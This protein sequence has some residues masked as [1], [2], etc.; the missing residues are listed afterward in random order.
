M[1]YGETLRQRSVP[2]WAYRETISPQR[3]IAN[4]RSLTIGWLPAENVDY[5]SIKNLIKDHTTPGKGKAI[6]ISIPGQQNESE[7][8][9]ENLL[10]SIF[11]DQHHAVSLFVKSKSGEIQRRLGSFLILCNVR[12]EY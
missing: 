11:L 3:P 5:D 4:A 9:F 1:K 8:S 10:F 12:F 2:Q 7:V 6:A